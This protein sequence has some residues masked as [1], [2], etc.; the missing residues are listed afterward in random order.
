MGP[1]ARVTTPPRSH[2]VPPRS[3]AVRPPSVPQHE[4]WSPQPPTPGLGTWRIRPLGATWALFRPGKLGCLPAE[5]G[6]P[7]WRT[8]CLPPVPRCCQPGPLGCGCHFA[9][10]ET[11]GSPLPLLWSQNRETEEPSG[12]SRLRAK[13]FQGSDSSAPASWNSEGDGGRQQPFPP[14]STVHPPRDRGQLAPGHR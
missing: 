6:T 13:A 10:K 2:A 4:T 5:M 9:W 11:G 8:A 12:W 14:L 1:L 3:H 7:S